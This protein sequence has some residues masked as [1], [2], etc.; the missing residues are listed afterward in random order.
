MSQE[1]P[2]ADRLRALED[3]AESIFEGLNRRGIYP[4]AGSIVSGSGLAGGG[5]LRYHSF[6]GS[7][8]GAELQGLWSV[9][10]YREYVARLGVVGEAR[11]A[12]EL[13]RA[14][15]NVTSLF[16]DHDSMSASSSAL[17]IEGVQRYSP[18]LD[19]FGLGPSLGPPKTDFGASARSLELVGQWQ[20]TERMGF[21]GRAGVID[22]SL[23]RGTN[24]DVPNLELHYD[25]SLAPGLGQ[26]APWLAVGLGSAFDSRNSA[27]LPDT[28]IFLAG[29]IWHL[30]SLQGAPQAVTRG[31]V[32]F[33][34]FEPLVSRS[35]I[36]AV[37]VLASGDLSSGGE[38]PFYLQYWLGGSH[39]LR[40]YSSYRLRGE[41]LLHASVEY[42]WRVA[43][44]I[45]V[46]PFVDIGTVGLSARDLWR[47]PVHVNPGIGVWIRDDE[48]F[49]FRIDWAYGR[50]GHRLLWSL[51][52]SF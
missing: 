15:A 29:A 24:D 19:F 28:G 37:R 38:T 2:W 45:N 31:V 32:D 52:P 47:A 4:D 6:G 21:V 36:A 49:Y 14:D 11:Q 23:S 20:P 43:P 16:N 40:G 26:Q 25:E 5:S 51:S 44:M 30:E 7:R 46:V 8:I 18:Q 50:E 34:W 33:R 42:R 1:N 9:R 27:D 12:L 39:S 35:G 13:E 10:G 3:R 48:R 41:A 22:V 17:Y